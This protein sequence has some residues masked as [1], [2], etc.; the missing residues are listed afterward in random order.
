[1]KVFSS[2]L[3]AGQIVLL[4]WILR[5]FWLTL[6]GR[7]RSA[8]LLIPCLVIVQFLFLPVKYRLVCSY[9][10]SFAYVCCYVLY[11]WCKDLIWLS[12]QWFVT[13]YFSLLLLVLL[14]FNDFS[15]YLISR[16]W[17]FYSYVFDLFEQSF[18]PLALGFMFACSSLV[19]NS[20]QTGPSCFYYS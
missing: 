12:Y 16:W 7:S 1:M 4:F 10:C 17:Y 20:G 9:I 19:W 2:V 13:D 3:N 15:S 5:Q 6:A 11:Y 18:S 14:I 8:F